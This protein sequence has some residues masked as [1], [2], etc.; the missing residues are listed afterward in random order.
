VA[1]H[2]PAARETDE[3]QDGYC[4]SQFHFAPAEGPPSNQGEATSHAPNR[5]LMKGHARGRFRRRDHSD[6]VNERAGKA[7]LSA[8]LPSA[9]NTA[10]ANIH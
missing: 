8:I 6:S 2:H 9:P 4:D 7:P 5:T 10:G 3:A 1:L